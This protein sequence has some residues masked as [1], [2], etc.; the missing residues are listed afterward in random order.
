MGERFLTGLHH[1][2]IFCF[3]QTTRLLSA[4]FAYLT[5][6]TQQTL[7]RYTKWSTNT[8]E[9]QCSNEVLLH[10]SGNQNF[11][12]GEWTAKLR[13]SGGTLWDIEVQSDW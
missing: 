10:L 1:L 13:V 3:T 12:A 7:Q 8:I 9:S 4:T 6:N 5:F 11:L 2:C